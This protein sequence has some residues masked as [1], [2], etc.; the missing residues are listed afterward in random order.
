M[1][2]GGRSTETR[3]PNHGG[4]SRGSPTDRKN[5]RR[6]TRLKNGTTNLVYAR[7]NP[8]PYKGLKKRSRT[9]DVPISVHYPYRCACR[10]ARRDGG[11]CSATPCRLAACNGHR[12]PTSCRSATPTSYR[13]AAPLPTCPSIVSR[14]R[15]RGTILSA[16]TPTAG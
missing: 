15:G 10:P 1:L 3:M 9:N 8:H 14:L 2:L 13:A 7:S 5:S 11:C 4:G 6:A 16:T 12:S